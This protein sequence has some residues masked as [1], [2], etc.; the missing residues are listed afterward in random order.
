VGVVCF[1][2]AVSWLFGALVRVAEWG[3]VLGLQYGGWRL[4]GS[5]VA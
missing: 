4:V 1:L 2:F 5:C 3:F